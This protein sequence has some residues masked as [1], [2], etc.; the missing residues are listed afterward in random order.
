MGGRP[1][2]RKL[3]QRACAAHA[4]ESKRRKTEFDLQ[5]DLQG[6]AENHTKCTQEDSFAEPDWIPT[7]VVKTEA[8]ETEKPCGIDEKY[9][10]KPAHFHQCTQKYS[11]GSTDSNEHKAPKK[12]KKKKSV[13]TD[14]PL[15]GTNT[16]LNH[17]VAS[18]ALEKIG[19]IL[20]PLRQDGNGHKPCKIKDE[21]L[22]RRLNTMAMCL[23]LYCSED[24]NYKFTHSSEVAAIGAG[25]SPRYGKQLRQYIRRFI[26]TGDLPEH[27]FS[28]NTSKTQDDALAS[29]IKQHLDTK[30]L[31]AKAADI[32]N[33]L[34]Q[35]EIQ[36][37]FNLKNAPS[38]R[39][40]QRWMNDF[41]YT[42]G[43]A[44]KGQYVDGHERDDVVHYRQFRFIPAWSRLEKRMRAY[45]SKTMQELSPVLN[46]GEREV[47][48]WFHD[49]S[50]FYANDRRLARWVHRLE[51]AKPYAKGEGASI[52]VADFVSVDGWLKGNDPKKNARIVMF[53]GKHRDGYLTNERIRLQLTRAIELA[54]AKYPDA[55]H[56]FIYDNATTHTKKREDAPNPSKM[57]LA[58]SNNVGD[59]VGTSPTGQK[60]RAKMGDAKFADGSPQTLYFGPDHPK[61]PG[62]FKGIANILRERGIDVSGLK[63]QCPNQSKCDQ[64]TTKCCARRVLSD[65]P[66]FVDIK[67]ALEEIAE[68]HE[69]QVLFLPKFHCELNPIEQ[70]WGYAKHVYRQFPPSKSEADLEA[71]M[72]ASLDAIPLESIRR[73]FNK[74]QRFLDAYRHGLNG[75]EATWANKKYRGHRVLPPSI[76][77]EIEEEC[78]RQGV[79]NN[80]RQ[81]K[82]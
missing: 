12:K 50:I 64:T 5:D 67:S 55:E 59:I 37:K 19:A 69:C 6:A 71:N 25:Y 70:C 42:W 3:A 15:G 41:G 53:P 62:Y 65:Q 43:N 22:L 18:D 39:T 35:V 20:Q 24:L 54:K 14:L 76:L 72:L 44:P 4:A 2:K 40:A 26:D 49:E 11:P 66:D 30:G 38:L 56:V 81:S 60:I 13:S 34:A 61:Y 79:F 63:L 31:H 58:P 46:P 33:Y 68:A 16:A 82:K 80:A 36:Q 75:E 8:P 57:T 28:G 47:M 7:E 52:M 77:E 23:R 10:P 27:M 29:D 17:Q 45:D 9:Q 32:I 73:F 51:R 1:G 74:S 78:R 21:I 48:V